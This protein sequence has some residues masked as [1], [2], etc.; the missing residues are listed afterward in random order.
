MN[1]IKKFLP[2]SLLGR[3]VL[4]IVT[5]LILLQVVSTWVFYDRHW[6]TVTR[7][8]AAGVAGDISSVI[9]SRRN[10]PGAENQRWVFYSAAT[11]IVSP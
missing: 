9:D 4:I 5:P 2:H 7:R 6:E 8:L 10:F 1:W 11:N 3:S